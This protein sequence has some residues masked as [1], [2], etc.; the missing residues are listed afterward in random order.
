MDKTSDTST[1]ATRS[2]KA[3]S[4][5]SLNRERSASIL[6]LARQQA[7]V[8]LRELAV[9]AG[10]SHATLSAYEQGRKIPSMVTFMRI[11]DAC[12]QSVDCELSPRI[13]EA[14]GNA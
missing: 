2:S 10:T 6:R 5:D 7:D 9:R 13:R 8:S 3:D 14:D 11:L 12:N 1:S 4:R